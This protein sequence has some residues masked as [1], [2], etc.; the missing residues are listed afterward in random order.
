[1]PVVA[2]EVGRSNNRKIGIVGDEDGIARQIDLL[3]IMAYTI[4][5]QRVPEPETA[6]FRAEGEQMREQFPALV[7]VQLARQWLQVQGHP[8]LAL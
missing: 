2:R 4:V 5:R 3:N 7:R 6:V 1:M 8:G